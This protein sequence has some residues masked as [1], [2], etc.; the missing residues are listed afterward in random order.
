MYKICLDVEGVLL[1]EIWG[2]VAEHFKNKKLLI[3]TKDEPDYNKLVQFRIPELRNS[4]IR[5]KD[6][7]SLLATIE[8]LE[9]AG[10]PT[11]YCRDD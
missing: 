7:I 11:A 5:Y 4:R 3:T 2:T 8:P 6:I 1:P 10:R 9:G